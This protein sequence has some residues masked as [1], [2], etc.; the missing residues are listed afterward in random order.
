MVI[1]VNAVP[2]YGKVERQGNQIVF[3]PLE[4]LTSAVVGELKKHYDLEN[5]DFSIL[6]TSKKVLCILKVVV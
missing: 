4:L 1:Y 3:E 2:Q 6:K 5:E